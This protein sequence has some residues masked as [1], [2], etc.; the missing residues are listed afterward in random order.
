VVAELHY[1]SPR[2][3]FSYLSLGGITMSDI[4]D[5]ANISVAQMALAWEIA[6]DAMKYTKHS[7]GGAAENDKGRVDIFVELFNRAYFSLL[8]EPKED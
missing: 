8:K 5:G 2:F 3:V 4:P 7:R 1:F 6:K